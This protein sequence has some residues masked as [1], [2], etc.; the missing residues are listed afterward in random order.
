MKCEP[1]NREHKRRARA[2]TLGG[3]REVKVNA[4]PKTR[5]VT[6]AE[7]VRTA[8]E[9]LICTPVIAPVTYMTLVSKF[10]LPDVP[11]AALGASARHSKCPWP[12]RQ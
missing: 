11:A 10:P 5:T 4:R 1:G 2:A 8:T 7:P 12:S 6:V 9:P 3:R